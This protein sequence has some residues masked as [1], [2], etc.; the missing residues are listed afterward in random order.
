MFL[1]CLKFLLIKKTFTQMIKNASFFLL[2][3]I[4]TK[5]KLAAFFL[6]LFIINI[7]SMLG[8]LAEIVG[9]SFRSFDSELIIALK[10][11]HTGV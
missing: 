3:P 4:S 10:T 6:Y 1:K 2:R 5:Q 9:G 8:V 7:V 11:L